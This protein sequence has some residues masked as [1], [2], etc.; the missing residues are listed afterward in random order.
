LAHIDANVPLP[1]IK[2]KLSENISS[3]HFLG[4]GL[5]VKCPQA[6]VEQPCNFDPFNPTLFV[7]LS[8]RKFPRIPVHVAAVQLAIIRPLTMLE[9][10]NPNQLHCLPAQLMV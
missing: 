5:I 1:D 2:A 4:A 10:E 3:H 6:P 9:P 7:L 8:I